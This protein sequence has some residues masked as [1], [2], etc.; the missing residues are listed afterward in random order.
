LPSDRKISTGSSSSAFSAEQIEEAMQKIMDEYAGGI[1]T[2]YR[3]NESRLVLAAK[4]IAELQ[5]IVP[6]LEANDM[7][8]LL[9]IYEVRER[10]IVCQSLIAHLRSRKETRWHSFAE[11]ADYPQKSEDGACYVNSVREN[12]EI[13]IIKRPLVKGEV[14]EHQN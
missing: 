14:Y 7:D 6:S 9:R 4:K 5:A 2:N 12:G 13:K 8:D 1:A 3:Y 10:L 11:H